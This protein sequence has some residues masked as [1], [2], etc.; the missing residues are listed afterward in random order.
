[1][2]EYVDEDSSKVWRSQFGRSKSPF[3]TVGS[4][5]WK[6]ASAG[7]LLPDEVRSDGAESIV[8]DNGTDDIHNLTP[9]LAGKSSSGEGNSAVR[10]SFI[11]VTKN[12]N[13]YNEKRMV[14]GIVRD[15]C[16]S[17]GAVYYGGMKPQVDASN[18]I[19]YG[20][21]PRVTPRSGTGVLL[22]RW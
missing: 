10:M 6:R 22:Q 1:M 15:P 9:Y 14:T 16:A 8:S 13:Y 12:Q 21:A 20:Y 3:A 19:L 5:R 2:L 18:V 4:E 7:T 17:C 11:R